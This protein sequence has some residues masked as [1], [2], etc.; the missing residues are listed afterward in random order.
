MAISEAK[1]RA[2]AKYRSTKRKQIQLDFRAEEV[3]R[4][5][6]YCEEK[7][8]KVATWCKEIIAQAMEEKR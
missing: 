2:D 8:V 3:E 6:A 7:G 4:I 1:K 5:K